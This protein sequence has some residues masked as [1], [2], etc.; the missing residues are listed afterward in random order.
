MAGTLMEAT[1]E[2][3]ASSLRDV[4]AR[5]LAES[6]GCAARH[7]VSAHPAN[8]FS[9]VARQSVALTVSI[10]CGTQ[11]VKKKDAICLLQSPRS[12]AI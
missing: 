6:V 10:F 2:L 11:K 3:W 12:S 9:F 7:L 5:R 8:R 4:K 1:L